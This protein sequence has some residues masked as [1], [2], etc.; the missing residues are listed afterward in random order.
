MAEVPL[1]RARARRWWVSGRRVGS[2]DRAAAFVDDVG[3]AVLFPARRLVLPSLWEA[4]TGEDVEPF[5]MGMGADE[6]K[7]WAW[8][9]E[10]PRRGRAWYGGFVAGR[11]SFLSPDLL[12]LLY[13]G[14]GGVDDHE[15]LP[16]SQTA[17]AMARALAT[18]PLPTAE[19]RRLVGDRSRYQRAVAELQRHLLVTSVGVAERRSGWPAVLL[20]LTVEAFDG[21]GRHDPV[22]AA[23][24]FVDTVLE[25]TPVDLSR[26]FR[27]SFPQARACL[28]ELTATGRATSEGGGVVAATRRW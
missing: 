25:T 6:Q 2:L 13:P 20:A 26:A 12:Q 23:D 8:K 15:M 14:A 11:G 19:L 5:A 4:V 17:H 28:D 3:F 9:D 24:R 10:L 7:V 1:G 27:W 18:G 21:G 16:L 22:A